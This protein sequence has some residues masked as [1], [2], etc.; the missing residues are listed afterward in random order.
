MT[1]KHNIFPR[2]REMAIN[3]LRDATHMDTGPVLDRVCFEGRSDPRA[4]HLYA[5]LL[6]RETAMQEAINVLDTH[7]FNP[8][9]ISG[10]QLKRIFRARTILA[11]GLNDPN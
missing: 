8:G 3:Q 6:K 5:R 4:N 7:L 10:R 2:Q 1:W 9:I 11:D